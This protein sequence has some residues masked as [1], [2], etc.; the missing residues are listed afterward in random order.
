M[1]ARGGGRD[2]RNGRSRKSGSGNHNDDDDVIYGVG[3]GKG[4][5]VTFARS[6]VIV[7]RLTFAN[8]VGDTEREGV[9]FVEVLQ[10]FECVVLARLEVACKYDAVEPVGVGMGTS[11]SRPD[12]KANASLLS[13]SHRAAE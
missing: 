7:R 1:A 10:V 13:S 8:G 2:M 3:R 11:I 5:S 12:D 4:G 9:V 6:T